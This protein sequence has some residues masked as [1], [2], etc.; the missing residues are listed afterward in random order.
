[1]S[2]VP[3]WLKTQGTELKGA[4]FAIDAGCRTRERKLPAAA[5]P[6]ESRAE[7]SASPQGTVNRGPMIYGGNLGRGDRLPAQCFS[8]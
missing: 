2:R 6:V 3:R 1:M 4:H 8:V 7:G 5:A